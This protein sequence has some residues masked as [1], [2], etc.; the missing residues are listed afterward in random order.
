[1]RGRQS[2][3]MGAL[4]LMITV[5]VAA[6]DAQSIGTFRWQLQPYCNVVTLA[7]TQV[8]G[9]YRV[10]G[11]D[12]QCGGAADK[13]SAIGTAFPNPDGTIGFGLTI[14]VTPG[15]A[16]VH[17][18]AA[19]A[20]G[21]FDGTWKDSAGDSGT[22]KFTP[23]APT[24]GQPRPQPIGGKGPAG[25]IF[26][27][28]GYIVAPGGTGEPLPQTGLRTMML[29]HAGKS[30][31]RAGEYMNNE[32]GEAN[33]GIHSAALGFGTTASGTEST[34]LGLETTASGA[35]ST[36]TGY[37]TIASASSAFAAGGSSEARGRAS[38]AAGDA[39]KATAAASSAFGTRSNA[40]GASAFAAGQ[41]TVA[42][43]DA[44]TAL[45]ERA[46]AL[47]SHAIAGGYLASA[48][49]D[50]SVV[51]GANASAAAGAHGSFVFG[52]LSVPQQNAL[53][54]TNPNE[55]VGR[56][57]G[58]YHLFS[59]A[60]LTTGVRVAPGANAWSSLSD[61]NSKEHFR[62]LDHDDVLAKIAAMPVREWNYKSQDAAIRHMGP[63]AQ[64]FRAAFGLGEDPLRISTIDADG[65]ALA[66]IRALEWRTRTRDEAASTEIEALKAE[67]AALRA[68]V[69]ALA[70]QQR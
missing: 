49:G 51:L 57:A 17:V 13:A 2:L 21:G 38:F 60:A 59:N 36:A 5:G 66:A 4:A 61:V 11:T 7:V 41:E 48:A 42:A 39:V 43:G 18:D 28:G 44:A 9:I 24:G 65:V 23:G 55:F 19:L 35:A 68:T 10:E 8:G 58:G 53:V 54:S 52:D 1:M 25:V 3:M 62:D 34:A 12:D 33:I 26:A 20:P 37:R 50:F 32:W 6:A 67:L 27:K 63:T 46:Y 22:F 31:F 40:S 29:W 16:P 64:D 15:G 14:V 47:G 69:A 45:G 70:A 30:A 56:F